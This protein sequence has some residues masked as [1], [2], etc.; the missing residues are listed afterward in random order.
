M[1]ILMYRNMSKGNPFAGGY[2]EQ[3]NV[4]IEAMEIIE[5]VANAH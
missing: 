5:S 1:F 4:Y 2:F 3:P